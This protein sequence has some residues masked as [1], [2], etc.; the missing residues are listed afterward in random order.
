MGF[1]SLPPLN[2][3]NY[4]KDISIESTLLVG[5]EKFIR[6]YALKLLN[7]IAELLHKCF[8][9]IYRDSESFEACGVLDKINDYLKCLFLLWH[10]GFQSDIVRAN[11]DSIREWNR[12]VITSSN[13]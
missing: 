1:Y 13:L 9:D 3:K 4:P 11:L 12:F 5:Y 6:I 7:G 2:I 8:W 10:S